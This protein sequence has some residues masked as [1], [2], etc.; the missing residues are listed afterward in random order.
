MNED[1]LYSAVDLLRDAVTEAERRCGDRLAI[2]ALGLVVAC[3]LESRSS[4]LLST[5]IQ[6]AREKIQLQKKN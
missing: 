4:E 3:V 6:V 2:V 5:S 1:E